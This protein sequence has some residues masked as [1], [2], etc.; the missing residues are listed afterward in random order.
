MKPLLIILGSLGLVVAVLQLVPK[1]GGGIPDTRATG[2]TYV[3]IAPT[4]APKRESLPSVEWARQTLREK[5]AEIDGTPIDYYTPMPCMG[6]SWAD[7]RVNG[8]RCWVAFFIRGHRTTAALL[9]GHGTT[10][11]RSYPGGYR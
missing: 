5:I 4:P 7:E 10:V 2:V 9:Y 11:T 8:E 6:I 1:G 3:R